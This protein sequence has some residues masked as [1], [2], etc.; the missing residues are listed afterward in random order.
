MY[1]ILT[2]QEQFNM[3]N[4]SAAALR[5]MKNEK[6][7]KRDPLKVLSENLQSI[8][9]GSDL[10][11]SFDSSSWEGK[12]KVD[13]LYFEQLLQKLNEEQ[14]NLVE[15]A[16]NVYFKDIRLIYEFVNLKPEI[17]GKNI[18]TKILEDSNEVSQQKLS[19]V[20]YEYL[21]S[22]FYGLAPEKR[23]DKYIETSRE[24]T[25][26][27]INEGVEAEEAIEFSVKTT[28]MENL[29]TKIAF[30]F[31]TWSRIHYLIES[32]DYGKVFDRKA[33]IDLVESFQNK[34]GSISKIVAAV[35]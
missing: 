31:A 29:L 24:L 12:V 25:K 30:P 28:V 19:S 6:V 15:S 13:V 5:K 11:E 8:N 27:L 32:E 33:L 23:V 4:E 21:D 16:L 34:V 26:T 2:E 10:F 3:M 17:Y 1:N 7:I 35:I 22:Y 18:N 9:I 14:V 20:I